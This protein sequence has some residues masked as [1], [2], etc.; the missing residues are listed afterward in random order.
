MR[1]PVAMKKKKNSLKCANK[2]PEMGK[3]KNSLLYRFIPVSVNTCKCFPFFKIHLSRDGT[4]SVIS[5]QTYSPSGVQEGTS[6]WLLTSSYSCVAK[7]LSSSS[8]AADT[9]HYLARNSQRA[10]A[11]ISWATAVTSVCPHHGR[12][13]WRSAVSRGGLK[14]EERATVS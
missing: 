11:E 6:I 5:Q 10:G 8:A 9:S 3:K 1:V 13:W 2:S 4:L 14:R 12:S 7:Q